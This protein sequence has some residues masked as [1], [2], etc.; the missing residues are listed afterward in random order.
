[1]LLPVILSYGLKGTAKVVIAVAWPVLKETE[2]L[3]I[4]NQA[5]ALAIAQQSGFCLA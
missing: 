4:Y 1:M 3:A 2:S 5:I